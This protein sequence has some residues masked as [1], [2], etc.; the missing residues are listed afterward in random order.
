[1]NEIQE[2]STKS[3]EFLEAKVSLWGLMTT[4]G[5]V[6]SLATLLGFLGPF[7]WFLDLFSHFSDIKIVK[8]TRKEELWNGKHNELLAMEPLPLPY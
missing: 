5:M 6:A 4:A 2:T 3:N 7:S 1:M 8:Y